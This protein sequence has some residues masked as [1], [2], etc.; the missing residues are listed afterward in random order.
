MYGTSHTFTCP[1]LK[2]LDYTV[3]ELEEHDLSILLPFYLL[4]FR[5]RVQPARTEEKRRELAGEMKD[6]V[7]KLTAA[8]ERGRQANAPARALRRR[9]RPGVAH[10]MPPC[11]HRCAQALA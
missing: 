10:G 3:E 5:K 8:L 11:F 4:K 7:E 1:A 6:L 2:L 9:M